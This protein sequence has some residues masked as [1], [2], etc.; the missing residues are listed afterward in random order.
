MPRNDGL[1]DS[2]EAAALYGCSRGALCALMRRLGYTPADT[3][4]ATRYGVKYW[5]HPREVLAARARAK[6]GKR[7]Q[8]AENIRRAHTTPSQLMA[9]HS[10]LENYRQRV[11]ARI[12]AREA[13][14][15]VAA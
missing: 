1:V 6:Q 14:R 2:A 4:D 7:I 8:A 5:W 3:S 10:R 9:R 13:T 12:A 15:Q 11:L